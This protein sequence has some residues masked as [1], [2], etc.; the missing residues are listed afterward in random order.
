MSGSKKIN[1][2]K[3]TNYRDKTNANKNVKFTYLDH[4]LIPL[5]F[6]QVVHTVF[7]H[8]YQPLILQL[9]GTTMNPEKYISRHFNFKL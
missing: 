9:N 2:K 4:L 3:C 1:P 6:V 5:I 7:Q 8:L